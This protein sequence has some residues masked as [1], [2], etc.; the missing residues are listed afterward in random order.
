MLGTG[1]RPIIGREE[2]HQ[3]DRAKLIP[4]I[5]YLE[6]ELP[7]FEIYEREIDWKVYQSQRSKRLEVERWIECLINATLDISKMFL[8]IKEEEIPE[9][10]REVLFKTGSGIYDKEEEAE[11]FSELA[12]IRNTLAHRY[13]DIKWQDIKRFF[14]VVPKL[15][16]A[17]LDYIK[18]ELER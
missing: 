1:L 14:Q 17:F 18:K 3:T 9:T 4:H 8:T 16:P 12:K 10:S 11:A 13:L 2:L 15:Y 7:F 6:K 5:E